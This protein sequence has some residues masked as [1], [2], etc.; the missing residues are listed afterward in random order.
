[1]TLV[2]AA[3][4]TNTFLPGQRVFDVAIRGKNSFEFKNID[5]AK[6]VGPKRVY[7][8]HQANVSAEDMIHIDCK[9]GHD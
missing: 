1:M 3:T 8:I 6:E 2:F 7:L 4:Y 9:H 5:V